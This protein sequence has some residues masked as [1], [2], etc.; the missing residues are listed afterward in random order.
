MSNGLIFKNNLGENS[1]FWPIWSD[2]CISKCI[3]FTNKRWNWQ[4]WNGPNESE[5]I[6]YQNVENN[7]PIA[8]TG[9]RPHTVQFHFHD[10]EKPGLSH[11]NGYPVDFRTPDCKTQRRATASSNHTTD[12]SEP[13]LIFN[14][15]GLC[16]MNKL[17][18]SQF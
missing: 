7:F 9:E 18:G 1:N 11:L 10:A 5:A 13:H 14:P 12:F 17:N 4:N 3:C 8:D 15:S 2:L 16:A 6:T